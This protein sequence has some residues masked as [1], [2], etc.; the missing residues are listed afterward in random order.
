M[1]LQNELNQ[2]CLDK[3]KRLSINDKNKHSNYILYRCM[4]TNITIDDM[5]EEELEE[6]ENDLIERIEYKEIER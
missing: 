1:S 6:F 3:L 4:N 5:S 2:E